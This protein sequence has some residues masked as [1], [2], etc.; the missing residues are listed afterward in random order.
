MKIF[1]T[2]EK[3][4]FSQIIPG[5]LGESMDE[6]FAKKNWSL[7]RR[8]VG[9]DIGYQVYFGKGVQVDNLYEYGFPCLYD[10][11]MVISFAEDFYKRNIAGGVG[12]EVDVDSV[13]A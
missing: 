11:E 13:R 10:N 12:G 3:W 2:S 7:I 5:P 1:L 4:S 8:K 9:S 6:Y